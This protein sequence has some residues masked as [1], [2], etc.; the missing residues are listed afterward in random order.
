[1]RARLAAMLLIVWLPA[2]AAANDHTM[3][4]TPDETQISFR[5]GATLH[6]VDGSANLLRG[7]VRVNPQAGTASGEIV[8]DALSLNTGNTSRDKKMHTEVLLSD[9]HPH[10][11]LQITGY[12][13]TL[14]S[15]GPNSL[16]VTGSFELHGKAHQIEFPA[17]ISLGT[18][19]AEVRFQLEIP[20]VDWGL[21]DPSKFVLRVSK[22]VKVTVTA[23]ATL[24]PPFS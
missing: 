21:K 2:T 1:M 22:V 18:N 19:T 5:L 6:T 7:S 3:T 14:E 17:Q 23:K 13:G 16:S 11:I 10:F 24:E 9:T 8:V 12:E 15:S 20:Y 4:F